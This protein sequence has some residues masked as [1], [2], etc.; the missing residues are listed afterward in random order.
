MKKAILFIVM[1]ISL[2]PA[3]IGQSSDLNVRYFQNQVICGPL[4]SSG[5][6]F[7]QK[8]APNNNY[9]FVG[10]LNLNVYNCTANTFY[11]RGREAGETPA[12]RTATSVKVTQQ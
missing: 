2:V 1:A 10:Y 7:T 11:I 9:D 8:F 3:A 12:R 4:S 6:G 5:Q